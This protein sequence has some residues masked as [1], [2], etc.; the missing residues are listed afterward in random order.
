MAE[1]IVRDCGLSADVAQLRDSPRRL[2]PVQKGLCQSQPA[3]TR[4][5]VVSDGIGDD[6]AFSG[7]RI[8][9]DD[10]TYRHPGQRLAGENL[11]ESPPIIELSSES[12]RLQE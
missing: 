8:D 6:P 3:Q 7:R 9:R 11:A 2:S 5:E 10:I 1:P 12:G 4:A